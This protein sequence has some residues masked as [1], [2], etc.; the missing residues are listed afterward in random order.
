[1]R[2]SG[3]SLG[4]TI[5]QFQNA[6]TQKQLPDFKTK[7]SLLESRARTIEKKK[8]IDQVVLKRRNNLFSS[9]QKLHYEDQID[10]EN[11]L[12]K[13]SNVEGVMDER[14]IKQDKNKVM[15]NICIPIFNIK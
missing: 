15:P 7:L 10:T 14:K 2:R 6:R 13:K 8:M 9:I 5:S 4:F 3:S 12:F 11:G 1:V